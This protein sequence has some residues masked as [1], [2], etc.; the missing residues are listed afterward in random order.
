MNLIQFSK[1]RIQ[2]VLKYNFIASKWQ[3]KD[4]NRSTS[5]QGM[6]NYLQVWENALSLKITASLSRNNI[7]NYKCTNKPVVARLCVQLE[8]HGLRRHLISMILQTMRNREVLIAEAP[9]TFCQQ[10]MRSRMAFK[11]GTLF[12]WDI[13]SKP[14][15]YQRSE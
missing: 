11:N 1:K 14:T 13:I 12:L 9:K 7:G 8:S 4:Y 6:Y 3:N 2:Y 15:R 10:I 5:F